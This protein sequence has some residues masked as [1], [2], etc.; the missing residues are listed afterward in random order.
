MIGW[1]LI[2]T[3]SSKFEITITCNVGYAVKVVVLLK[4]LSAISN[5]SSN[6]LLYSC[7]KTQISSIVGAHEA[8]NFT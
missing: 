7:S 5:S 3:S 1:G 4:K 6:S 2:S 8:S